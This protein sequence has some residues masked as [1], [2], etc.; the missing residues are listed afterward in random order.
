[1]TASR[2][3][4]DGLE[5]AKAMTDREWQLQ[6]N[7]EKETIASL[8]SINAVEWRAEFN[9]HFACSIRAGCGRGLAK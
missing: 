2:P 6:G 4:G 7:E 1:M 3:E 8:R 9:N 5:L